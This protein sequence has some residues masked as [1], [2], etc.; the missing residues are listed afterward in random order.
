[1]K[2]FLKEVADLRMLLKATP[3]GW[4]DIISDFLFNPI[5]F[6]RRVEEEKKFGKNVQTWIGKRKE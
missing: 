6:A 3:Y 1:M 2:E 5:R 4:L